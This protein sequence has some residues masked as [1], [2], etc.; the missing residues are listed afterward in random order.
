MTRR[1]DQLLANLG[2]CTRSEVKTFLKNNE[3]LAATSRLKNPSEKVPAADVRVNGEPL[4]HPDGIFIMLNKPVG[5]VCSHD[6]REG[7]RIYDLLPERW[8]RRNPQ[9][10]SIGRLDKETSG[11]LL[12]TDQTELVHFYTS[13]KNKVPKRYLARLDKLPPPSLVEVFARGEILL[14][15]EEKP[16]APAELRLSGTREVSVILTEGKYHQVR[17][18]FAASSLTVLELKRTSFGRL[19]L[20]NLEAGKWKTVRPQDV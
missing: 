18:M 8:R 13:P 4:D 9:V 2:Y 16:C 17:R 15:G 10:T 5:L 6:G 11:L 12:L 20:G 14:D 7:P 3:V 1:I 19:E